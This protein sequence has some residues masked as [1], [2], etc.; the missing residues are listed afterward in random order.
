M[1]AKLPKGLQTEE[2][3][4]A[5]I[6]GGM[7][8]C[9]RGGTL[10]RQPDVAS[11]SEPAAVGSKRARADSGKGATAAAPRR[12]RPCV[13]LDLTTGASPSPANRASRSDAKQLVDLIG[14]DRAAATEPATPAA[15]SAA[16]AERPADSA[17]RTVC[18]DL[19]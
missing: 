7:S 17:Q 3:V 4:R 10:V 12:A 1:L 16:A 5:A 6:T 9:A 2:T 15:A 11:A 8:A 19:T 13:P 18:I 14:C